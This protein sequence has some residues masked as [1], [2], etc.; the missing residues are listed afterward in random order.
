MKIFGLEI[1]RAQKVEDQGVNINR[2]TLPKSVDISPAS[3]AP[4]K[5]PG[6][7]YSTNRFLGRGHFEPA[8]YNLA[9][10]GRIE[11]TDGYVRQAFKKKIGLMLKEGFDFVG[12]NPQRVKYIKVRLAQI[13]MASGIPTAELIRS[14][15]GALIKK[16]N[17]FL[18]KA[19]NDDASGGK[20]R[21]AA[22][23]KTLKPVAG[24]FVLPA[25]MM[26]VDADIYGRIRKWRQRTYYG[27]FKDFKPQDVIHFSFDR[28]EGFLFGTPTLVPVVDDI[29]ALRK[30]E[31]N[32]EL[33]IYQHL[34]PLF[35]Y[36]VGTPEQPAGYTE[37]GLREID[38]V[39]AE[40][41]DMPTEGGI[42]TPER[43][44]IIAI[45]AEGRALRAESYLD[46][47]KKRVFSGLGVSAVDMGEGETANRAT[48]DNMSRALID[49]VK[50]FQDVVECQFDAH[51]INELLLE[52]T[53]DQETVLDEE[54]LVH[55]KF[56]EIDI[57]KRI[58]VENQAADMFAKHGLTHDELR[59]VLGHEVW[60]IPDEEEPD[61]P[62]KFPDWS[63]SF[64]KLFDEP[65]AIIQA[66]DEPFTPAARAAGQNRAT[67]VSPSDVDEAGEKATQAEERKI[68]ARPVA[69]PAARKSRDFILKDNFLLPMFNDIEENI[70]FD[71]L[72]PN[73]GELSNVS[74]FGLLA[75]AQATRMANE[76]ANRAF[77]S[78][79][80]QFTKSTSN[81]LQPGELL[82][83]RAT[84]EARAGRFVARLHN[85]LISALN[86]QV[87]SSSDNDKIS[88]V[89][90][91]F[92]SLRFRT[93]L[94]A[95]VEVRRARN[96]GFV[97]AQ[98]TKGVQHITF[99]SEDPECEKCQDLTNNVVDIHSVTIED[100]PPFHGACRCLV[101]VVEEKDQ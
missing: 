26:E 91:V 46:H 34:F 92:K 88:T 67:S 76:V 61:D 40:I 100:I 3:I 16:S 53:F 52:S 99:K 47:F 54:N 71:I 49:D 39:K 73:T 94:I 22:N 59:K 18:V 25:E 101:E 27:S 57:D 70:I 65:K 68:K 60:A 43:H 44:E 9:L 21:V 1:K 89:R 32:I 80:T 78:F 75:R 79:I 69:S 6:F 82:A 10:I 55:L 64:W 12:S 84:V 30:I 51:V 98:R 36:K 28:K 24:Y 35:Q 5:N 4:I 81:L 15:G 29:R 85:S 42:V 23:G 14:V 87:D 11:D 7:I 96:L 45:G 50:D 8:E 63:R 41:E 33:L 37:D 97:F 95:D 17:G 77:S 31:E 58:K 72:N 62:V 90:A 56:K 48:A 66:I 2:V 38:V 93:K 19:R 83:V 86:R 74:Y 13:S 20:I